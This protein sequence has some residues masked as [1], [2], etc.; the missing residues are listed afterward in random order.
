LLARGRPMAAPTFQS[1]AL[2]TPQ[3]SIYRGPHPVFPHYRT[4]T[5]FFSSYKA[6]LEGYIGER[7]ERRQWREERPER[8]AAVGD[9][10]SRS[11]GKESAGYRN[12]Q[13][14]LFAGANNSNPPLC[15]ILW[16]LSW[17]NK[18]VPPPA[19]TGGETQPLHFN[20]PLCTPFLTRPHFVR[21][22]SPRG[23]GFD[24]SAPPTP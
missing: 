13:V 3:L 2:P 1:L 20:R 19:G 15:R 21:P 22:P 23:R 14:A 12:R 9:R 16:V 4:K 6:G 18:K 11:A 24:P 8:V 10:R 5:F 7:R 17:R